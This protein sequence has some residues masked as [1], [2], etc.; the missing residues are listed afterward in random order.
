MLPT[1][2]WPHR[3][4]SSPGARSSRSG[5]DKDRAR[6]LGH[7]AVGCLLNFPCLPRC[8]PPPAGP[9]RRPCR[10]SVQTWLLPIPS[11]SLGACPPPPGLSVHRP[12]SLPCHHIP[13]MALFGDLLCRCL[14][15]AKLNGLG[16]GTKPPAPMLS[17]QELQAH[18]CSCTHQL[19]EPREQ[20][21]ATFAPQSLYGS[22][23]SQRVTG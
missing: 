2:C 12:L 19:P 20:S 15:L 18:R 16:T 23:P 21:P 10:P 4:M 5:P 6:N 14:S 17:P 3:P 1:A 9:S 22:V 8:P 13:S 7:T 11:R